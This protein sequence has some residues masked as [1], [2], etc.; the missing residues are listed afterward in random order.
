M[1]RDAFL[2]GVKYFQETLGFQVSGF[3]LMPDHVHMIISSDQPVSKIIGNIK[4]YCGREIS[5]ILDDRG[6]VWED[7]YIK[8][9]IKSYNAYENILDT[10]H[11]NPV[12]RGLVKKSAD[13]PYSSYEYFKENK[14]VPFFPA[15]KLTE[16]DFAPQP[17]TV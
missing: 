8:L 1:F 11:A 12:K 17:V 6:K 16:N 2:R 15:V 3:C 14:P 4:S 13:Y 9:E 7:G 10:I 5:R